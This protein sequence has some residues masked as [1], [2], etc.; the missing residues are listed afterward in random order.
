[1]DGR[2][3]KIGCPGTGRPGAAR[4]APPMGT[5]GCTVGVAAGRAG[6]WYTG[7]GPVCGTIMRGGGAGGALGRGAIG[8]ADVALAVAAG[9]A[10]TAGGCAVGSGVTGRAG[11]ME[12]P[13][14]TDDAGGTIA[15]RAVTT[16][17]AGAATEAGGVADFDIGC[18]GAALAGAAERVAGFS[19]AAGDTDGAAGRRAAGGAAASFF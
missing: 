6:A 7:R 11:A 1:M 9:G 19:A 13:E 17:A 5:P 15:G 12:A 4:V 14:E 8:A 2:R 16:G 3:W 10:A 18:A